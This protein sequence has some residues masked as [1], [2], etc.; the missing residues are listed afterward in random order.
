LH[1]DT[2]DEYAPVVQ[3][4]KQFKQL[5]GAISMEDIRSSSTNQKSNGSTPEALGKKIAKRAKSREYSLEDSQKISYKLMMKV[6]NYSNSDFQL[7]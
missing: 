5:G 2:T 4:G 7:I 3:L 6:D 1:S